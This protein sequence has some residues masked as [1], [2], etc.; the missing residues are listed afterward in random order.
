[1]SRS[2]RHVLLLVTSYTA[3]AIAWGWRLHAGDTMPSKASSQVAAA[4]LE[5]A[6][7]LASAPAHLQQAALFQLAML[8]DQETQALHAWSLAL[9]EDRLR[10]LTVQQ[11]PVP[12]PC[13][14]N[15]ALLFTELDRLDA[16]PVDDCRLLV[17]AAGDRLE[18][19]HQIEA[20]GQL[21][22]R[23][24]DGHLYDLAVEIHQRICTF[25]S[26]SWNHVLHLTEA[27]RL[28][29]RPAAALRTVTLWIQSGDVRIREE[30]HEDALDLQTALLLEGTRFAEASR[31]SLD[32]LRS[33][34]LDA[35]IPPRRLQRALLATHAASE[36]AELLPWIERHLRTRPEHTLRVE[37]I[38]AGKPVSPDY[39]RWLQESASIADLHHHSSIACDGFF[40]LAAAGS[41]RVLAR[42][43]ALAVQTGRSS[44]FASLLASLQRRFSIIELAQALAAGGAPSPARDLLTAH[45]K[46]SPNHRAGWRLLTEI[47]ASLR[48]STSA[49]AV[50]QEFLRRFPDDVPAMTQLAELQLQSG[51]LPQALRTLQQ[52]PQ[53]QLETAALRQIT[54]LAI[55]L[56]EIP[57]AQQAQQLIVQRSA[58]PSMSD[59]LTLAA[60]T[61]QHPGAQSEAALAEAIAR[62][63]AQGILPAP[64]PEIP[65]TGAV[66]S[67]STAAHPE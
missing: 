65:A 3:L 10:Q 8:P 9:P 34:K 66:S 48:G 50:W 31:L 16:P 43:H 54:A 5:I 39:Q 19:A 59:A 11:G 29:R 41:L 23:A 22:R 28:A 44:D 4:R 58:I 15:T 62:L 33:L 47:D 57:A 46:N 45:L 56:D 26:A 53:D 64:T 36:S 35:P 63:P 37:E 25:P 61:R 18:E 20:L 49:P 52:I 13:P 14:L 67:F 38:A 27:A 30:Q 32:A 6:A 7:R 60:I 51:Q 1:M 42:L 24:V 12:A 17:S 2:A 55:E 21:A 40:R